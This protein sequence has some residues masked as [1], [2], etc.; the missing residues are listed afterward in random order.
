[1]KNSIRINAHMKTEIISAFFLND[2]NKNKVE[3]IIETRK[4]MKNNIENKIACMSERFTISLNNVVCPKLISIISMKL[5]HMK[6]KPIIYDIMMKKNCN[7]LN[8]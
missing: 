5:N 2:F 3:N 8:T 7:N 6:N 1:M 4:I